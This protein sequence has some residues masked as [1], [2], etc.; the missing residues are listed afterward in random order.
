MSGSNALRE[1]THDPKGNPTLSD[2]P[3]VVILLLAAGVAGIFTCCLAFFIY[4]TGAQ[5]LR[6]LYRDRDVAST[7]PGEA[8][9]TATPAKPQQ[10]S[11]ACPATTFHHLAEHTLPPEHRFASRGD[12]RLDQQRSGA[13]HY[14]WGL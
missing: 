13:D 9:I 14:L 5:Y 7:T 3:V 12:G 1:G 8:T 2:M 6:D 11:I 10:Q 4:F